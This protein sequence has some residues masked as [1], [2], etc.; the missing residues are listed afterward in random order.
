[1]ESTKKCLRTG[2]NLVGCVCLVVVVMLISNPL[3]GQAP[4]ASLNELP[5]EANGGAETITII[6]GESTI[7]QA[8]WP[9]IRVAVTDPTIAD[10][11]VL[12]PDQ[13]LLQGKKV[14]STDLIVWSEGEKQVQ[15][16]KARVVM[17]LAHH[18]ERLDELFPDSLLEVSQSGEVLVVGGLLRRANQAE[19]LHDYLDKIGVA[20]VDMTSVA[21]VQ[22]VQLQVR[23]AEVSKQALRML[24][25]SA[26]YSN[27]DFFTGIREAS[28]SGGAVMPSISIGP[29][30]GTAPAASTYA[31]T[32]DVVAS[33][34]TTVFFGIP[35]SDF[36]MFFQALAENQY[37]RLLSNPTLVALSGEEASFLAG[38]EFPIPVVQS[39]GGGGIGTSITIEYR[40]Y[41]VRLSFRPVVLGDGTI[42]LYVAP[43]VSELTS[44]GA[45]EIEG[46]EVPALITRKAATT[47]ELK[48]GQTFAMAGLLKHNVS[49]VRSSVPGLGDLP[50]IGPLFRSVSYR[51]D[52]T[53]LVV[54]VTA[55][56][57]EPM[58]LAATPPLPGALH[59]AP[60]DWELYVEGRI[61]GKEPA[62]INPTDA[63]WLKQIGLDHL[64]GPGAW[65]S[66]DKP[67]AESQAETLPPVFGA[68]DVNGQSAEAGGSTR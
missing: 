45:V 51:E 35:S 25:M 54:L 42:R 11:K 13:I 22:Q 65:D 66:Y 19:Q 8:P 48:S 55:S 59:V 60:T 61:E 52:E 30:E 28:A 24:G 3:W 47:L 67:V 5:L 33:L 23:I 29:P 1:M 12:T 57:V 15:K 49:A 14:G 4:A 17:D 20:Y 68:E 6:V 34:G 41:G 37:L 50:V 16:W 64:A 44:V 9:T 58:S 21:G 36:S 2:V 56:L 38:G 62:R 27:E 63:A 39:S 26:F 53:E 31:F 32:S 7:V 18:K 40:E 10:V 43:E 46:F